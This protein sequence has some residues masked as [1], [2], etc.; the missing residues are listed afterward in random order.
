MATGTAFC[1][2]I[3]SNARCEVCGWDSPLSQLSTCAKTCAILPQYLCCETTKELVELG[4]EADVIAPRVTFTETELVSI[5]TSLTIGGHPV[6]AE[7]LER[8]AKMPAAEIETLGAQPSGA[9]ASNYASAQVQYTSG[10]RN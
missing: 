6:Q 2:R 7:Q 1:G 8:L 4:A 10:E 5:Q 9:R 3:G